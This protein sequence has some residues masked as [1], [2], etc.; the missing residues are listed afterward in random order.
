MET[1]FCAHV[2]WLSSIEYQKHL[3][4]ELRLEEDRERYTKII[5]MS[6]AIQRKLEFLQ[7]K[8]PQLWKENRDITWSGS[9]YTKKIQHHAIHSG[10]LDKSKS[11]RP[12]S[13]SSDDEEEIYSTSVIHV[14][15]RRNASLFKINQLKDNTPS[16]CPLSSTQRK[17]YL[18]PPNSPPVQEEL[19]LPQMIHIH[20]R[21]RQSFKGLLR[22]EYQL[23]QYSISKTNSIPFTIDGTI[24]KTVHIGTGEPKLLLKLVIVSL[25][26]Q[27]PECQRRYGFTF[28]WQKQ[29]Q[30]RHQEQAKLV[31]APDSLV[32]EALCIWIETQNRKLTT[33]M[34][35]L[36]KADEILRDGRKLYIVYD[37]TV[38]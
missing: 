21:S 4:K 29:E 5:E 12:S 1:D 14:A 30:E 35:S 6:K 7:D 18:T 20:K 33:Q 9:F 25:D 31:F 37:A 38:F 27:T 8:R 32:Q 23:N 10:Q 16:N 15:V 36:K 3:V 2:N 11:T 26:S 13:I 28:W 17:D 19:V 24:F 22:R 34:P